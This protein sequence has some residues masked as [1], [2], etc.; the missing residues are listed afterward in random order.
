MLLS[1]AVL[2]TKATVLAYMAVFTELKENYCPNLEGIESN[3]QMRDLGSK[4]INVYAGRQCRP[5]ILNT[6]IV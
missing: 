3:V 4:L 1:E 2:A 6:T 5:R